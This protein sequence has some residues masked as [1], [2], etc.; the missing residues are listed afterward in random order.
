MKLRKLALAPIAVALMLSGAPALAGTLTFQGVTFASSFAGNVLTIEI[1][2]AGRTGDWSSAVSM[3]VIAIKD[4]GTYSGV[5]LLGPGGAW[6][7]SPNELDANGCTGGVS[8]GACFSHSAVALGDDMIFNFAFDGGPLSLDAPHLKVHFLDASGGKQGSLLSQNIATAIPEPE[9]YA[10]LLAGLGVLGFAARR[11]R[12]K[13][14]A[15]QA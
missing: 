4:V 9:T 14:K 11:R 15:V 3:D 6:T 7:Y 13:E 5:S 10:M 12:G 2:A 8:G 1:D